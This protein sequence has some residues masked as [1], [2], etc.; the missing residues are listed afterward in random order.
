MSEVGAQRGYREGFTIVELL[1]VIVVIAILAAITVVAYT[2]ITQQANDTAVKN[3]LAQ[4][5]KKF[6]IWKADAGRYPS[7]Y[8]GTDV[9]IRATGARLSTSAYSNFIICS[10]ANTQETYA[11]VGVSKSG[12]A[13]AISSLNPA[14]F[15][16]TGS[17]SSGNVICPAMNIPTS[18]WTW[19]I[20]WSS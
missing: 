17:M 7:T 13:Y 4:L 11:A 20:G 1:I 6:E 8:S 10:Q 12:R 19:G 5:H 2:G 14:V 15:E 3:D 18:N 9:E 16:Y